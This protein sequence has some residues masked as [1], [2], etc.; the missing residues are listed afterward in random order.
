MQL[1]EYKYLGVPMT[2]DGINYEKYLE[3]PMQAFGV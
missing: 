1:T 2:M 3:M